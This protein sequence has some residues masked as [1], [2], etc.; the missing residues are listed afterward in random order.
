VILIDVN[1]LVYAS[2]RSSPFFA[3]AHSW[4]TEQFNN[5]PR[6]GLPWES[7]LGFMRLAT[8]SA[9]HR[10]PVTVDRAWRQVEAWLA[11]ENVWIPTPG[12]AHRQIL[13][14]LLKNLGGGGK[15]VPDAH[16]AALAIEHGLTLCSTDGDFARFKPLRWINPLVR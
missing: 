4:V 10:H 5:S 6:I 3:P 8:R 12:P 14:G 2:D 7:L 1:L 11:L 15:L 9:V 13:A 16:L